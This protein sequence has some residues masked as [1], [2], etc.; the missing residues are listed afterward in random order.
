[1]SRALQEFRGA[2]RDPQRLQQL[3]GDR[4]FP[5]VEGRSVTFVYRGP[6]D[7]VLLQHWIHGLQAAQPFERIAPELWVLEIDLPEG[8]RLE[9]KLEIRTHGRRRLVNDPL[10]P[11]LAHNPFGSNS[12]VQGAGY[13]EPDW[14]RRD[15]ESRSGSL[16]EL[17]IPSSAFGGERRVSVYV[18]ARFHRRR[19]YPLLVAH[20]GHDYR[21]YS[22][23]Q[24]VLD[25]LIDRLE[26]PPMIVALTD[27]PDRMREYAADP[28]HASFLVDDLL[29]ALEDR[30]PLVEHPSGRGLM[31]ASFGAVASLSAAWQRPG[32]YGKLL[33]QSGSFLFTD[34]GDHEGGPVFDP[35]VE[36]VRRFRESPGRPAERVYLSCG[37]YEGMIHYNRAMAALLQAQG[38]PLLFEEARD[39]HNWENWRDRLRSGLS[40][41]FPGPLWMVYE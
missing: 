23:L 3:L 4:E 8:S 41:L 9:Y 37:A 40:W 29:P 11:K 27:S 16:E 39:G 19:R 24:T 21:R 28:R 15:P 14:A 25:N 12:V 17:A 34:I 1:M 36:F 7:Q 13:E 6:A 5:I 35:V 30:Y 32:I 18:P 38:I 2:L 20:D 31:G 33:L 10:N 22:A 26:I